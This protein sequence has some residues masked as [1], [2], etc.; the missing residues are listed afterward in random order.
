MAVGLGMVGKDAD[1]DVGGC[2]SSG[3]LGSGARMHGREHG[4]V[5]RVPRGVANTVTCSVSSPRGCGHVD[6]VAGGAE[7]SGSMEMV[8]RGRNRG[9]EEGG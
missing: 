3:E 5:L 2:R 1:D 7:C 9:A 6:G 8:A 4:G